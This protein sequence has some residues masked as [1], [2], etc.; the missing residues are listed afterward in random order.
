MEY[1]LVLVAIVLAVLFAARAN[2]PIQAAITS[3][4]SDASSV[5]TTAVN[6]VKGRL[7]L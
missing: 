3:V 4:S 1:L 2:G 5:I 6:D 7:G